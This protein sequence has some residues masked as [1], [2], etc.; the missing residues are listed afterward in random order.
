MPDKYPI[1]PGIISAAVGYGIKEVADAVTGVPQKQ[2]IKNMGSALMGYGTS[3]AV[4]AVVAAWIWLARFNPKGSK[5]GGTATTSGRIPY[6]MAT[7]RI[8]AGGGAGTWI[9]PR[10]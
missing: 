4:S 1:I 5:G 8:P 7:A 10:M 6:P 9:K 2:A 3:A